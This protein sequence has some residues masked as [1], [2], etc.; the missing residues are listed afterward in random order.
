MI[1]YRIQDRGR[2]VDELLDPEQQWSFP[3]S[4][5]EIIIFNYL[6]PI[7]CIIETITFKYITN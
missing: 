7:V 5:D 6:I 3:A 1:G 2:D 4:G